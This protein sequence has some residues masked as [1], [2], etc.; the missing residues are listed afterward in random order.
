VVVEVAAVELVIS[1]VRTERVLTQL[2][3][4]DPPDARSKV[5]APP[6]I[7]IFPIV[8]APLSPIPVLK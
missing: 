8:I 5:P 4:S 3:A 1:I 2:G 6:G 7:A